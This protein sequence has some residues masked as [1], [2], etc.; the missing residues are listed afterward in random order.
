MR[1]TLKISIVAAGLL[2]IV[3]AIGFTREHGLYCP[4]EIQKACEKNTRSKDGKPGEHYW[5]NRAEYTISAEID[6]A[7]HAVIGSEEVYYFNNGPDTLT[8]LIIRLYPDLYRIGSPRDYDLP[9]AD[10]TDGVAISHLA[11][12]DS[13]L[14]DIK[15]LVRSGTNLFIPLADGL[16]PGKKLKL[17]VRWSYVLPTELPLR[18][19]K[20][21]D[22]AYFVSYWYPQIAVYDD[23]TG[24]DKY[25]YHGVVGHYT[26]FA[27]FDVRITVPREFVVWATGE[28]RNPQEILSEN[29]LAKYTKALT[30]DKIVSVVTAKDRKAGDITAANDMNTWHYRAENVTDFA[31]GAS[32]YYL[33]DVTSLVVD[34]QTGRR[35]IIG[36]VYK[37]ESKSFRKAAEICRKT[38]DYLSSELP[39]VPYPS[40]SFTAFD[41][42]FAME[43]PMMTT[44]KPC[45]G[46]WLFCHTLSHEIAHSYFPFYVGANERKYAFMDEG[47]AQM[48]P[49]AFQT[50][51]I[52]SRNKK[53]DARVENNRDYEE[54]AGKETQDRPPAVLSVNMDRTNYHVVN[55]DRP[56]AAYYFLQDMLGEEL[57]KTALQEFMN[58]WRHKHPTPYDF[59]NTFNDVVGEDLGWYWKPWFFEFG[60]PDL[61]L[62]ELKEENGQKVIIVEKKGI[63]PV[64]VKVAVFCTDGSVANFYKTARAW[65]KGN[66]IFSIAIE[67]TRTVERIEL[68]DMVIPDIDRSNNILQ[69]K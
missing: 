21:R 50:R 48:L 47:W 22:N 11:I 31:F 42:S 23:I 34:R 65:D 43:F 57:F 66:D 28:L 45:D 20:Y 16:K 7:N 32:D 59:Y 35:A 39:G 8:Q 30:S 3:Y 1:A 49:M 2:C 27:D 33:W 63:I 6:T 24:W 56:G 60:Y 69:V 40:P 53:Y 26:D 67:G 46:E 25:E 51:E 19:G 5:Q 4:L 14:P 37:S 13:E 58:R 9:K 38:I 10:I 68:G 41:G 17:S 12:N 55:Y 62:K 64:P 15:D 54:A 52:S 29:I 18:G 36:A 44:M 61:G